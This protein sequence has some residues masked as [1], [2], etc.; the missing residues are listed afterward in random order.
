MFEFSCRS[1]LPVATLA[2]WNIT[3]IE[4]EQSHSFLGFFSPI[5]DP[6]GPVGAV[7]RCTHPNFAHT[8]QNLSLLY[9]CDLHS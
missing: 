1:D 2:F 4:T 9:I 7:L 3:N 8:R 6:P 5:L